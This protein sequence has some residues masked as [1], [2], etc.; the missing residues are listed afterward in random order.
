MTLSEAIAASRDRNLN[1]E[2]IRALVSTYPGTPSEA[3]DEIAFKVAGQYATREVDFTAADALANSMFAFA[4]QHGCL[5]DILHGV[6]LAFDAGEFVPS[7]DP[8]GTDPEA[9]YTRPQIAKIIATG[10]RSNKSLERT[11]ER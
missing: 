7:R 9:K 1:F 5:G 6:F 11:R 4:A 3:L 8:S 10:G 2:D